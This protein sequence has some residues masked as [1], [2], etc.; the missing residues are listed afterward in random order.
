MKAERGIPLWASAAGKSGAERS[1]RAE[2]DI[3]AGCYLGRYLSATV[4]AL[5]ADNHLISLVGA[6]GLEPWTR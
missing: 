3:S 4:A 1:Q 6:Q 5:F 2:L